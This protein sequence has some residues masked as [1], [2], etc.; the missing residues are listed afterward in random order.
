MLRNIDCGAGSQF[1]TADSLAQLFT[2][3]WNLFMTKTL[4]GRSAAALL[5]KF[6]L[7]GALGATDVRAQGVPLCTAARADE[8]SFL[9]VNA[10]AMDKMMAGMQIKPSGDVDDD[11]AAM[12]IPHHEGAIDMAIAE[13]RYGKNEQLRRIAE[14][15]IVDQQQ[16][17]VAMQLALGQ[18]LARSAPDPTQFPSSNL[19]AARDTPADVQKQ[20]HSGMD[21]MSS[22]SAPETM[23]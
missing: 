9:A 20:S 14:E 22:T 5:V 6:I 4:R 18:P 19:S 15:I 3:P 7:F 13:L 1:H 17:I 10:R 8:A 16:E 2:N 11:F 12:M 23:R 21:S